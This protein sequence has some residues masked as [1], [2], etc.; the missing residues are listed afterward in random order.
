MNSIPTPRSS[1]NTTPSSKLMDLDP[2]AALRGLS[3]NESPKTQA[4]LNN[5]M[6]RQSYQGR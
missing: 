1:A 5:T 6:A 2:Y 3:L 4:P